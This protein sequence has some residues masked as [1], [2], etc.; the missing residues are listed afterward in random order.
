MER[1]TVIDNQSESPYD[2]VDGNGY[3]VTVPPHSQ[4]FIDGPART[5]TVIEKPPPPEPTPIFPLLGP[6]MR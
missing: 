5:I 1:L 4:A 2:F 6:V 3:E